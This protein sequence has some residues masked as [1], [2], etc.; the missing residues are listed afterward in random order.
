MKNDPA[1]NDSLGQVETVYRMDWHRSYPQSVV[2]VWA[3][4]SNAEEI[5]A[6]MKYP[7]TL[8]PRPGGTIHID[9]SSQGSL[10]GVVCNFEPLRLLV[11]TWGDSLV[12]W[13]IE[14]AA[15]ETRLH[16]AHVGV[17]TDLMVGLGA[18]WHAFLDQLEDHLSGTARPNRYRELKSRYEVVTPSESK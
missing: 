15:G 3:A 10:E 11:Y 2:R 9:F 13:E 14:E 4:I 8:D 17:Q 7:T 6:W 18:G 1:T 12:K 16:L 5:T